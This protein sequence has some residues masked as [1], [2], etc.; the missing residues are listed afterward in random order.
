MTDIEAEMAELRTLSV[1]LCTDQ[2]LEAHAKPF[3]IGA[4]CPARRNTHHSL[5]VCNLTCY[6]TL[7]PQLVSRL[8]FYIFHSNYN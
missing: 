3:V 5:N 2:L 7:L 8:V 6:H 4:Y 1:T